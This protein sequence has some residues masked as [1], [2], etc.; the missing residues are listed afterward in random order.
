MPGPDWRAS[1]RRSRSSDGTP[2]FHPDLSSLAGHHH[3]GQVLEK[4]HRVRGPGVPQV[5]NL[6]Q[7]KGIG[8]GPKK[9]TPVERGGGLGPWADRGPRGHAVTAARGAG[10]HP[11]AVRS[12]LL[13][14]RTAPCVPQTLAGSLPCVRR[15]PGDGGRGGLDASGVHAPLGR[16]AEGLVPSGPCATAVPPLPSSCSSTRMRTSPSWRR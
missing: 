8:A 13:R 15:R 10:P 7:E 6:L 16:R 1:S 14:P 2:S 12:Q 3:R 4:P 9:S 11:R 5:E